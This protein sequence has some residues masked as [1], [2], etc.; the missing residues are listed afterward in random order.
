MNDAYSGVPRHRNVLI[1]PTSLAHS[2]AAFCLTSAN[3]ERDKT[4]Y[5]RALGPECDDDLQVGQLVLYDEF[6]SFGNTV[7]LFDSATNEVKEMLLLADEDVRLHLS[8]R[9]NP[10]EPGIRTFR[11]DEI[12][13]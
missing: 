12:P 4:G 7:K 3:S 11:S 13:P 9:T 10:Y 6:A 8:T 2:S 5:I 1:E